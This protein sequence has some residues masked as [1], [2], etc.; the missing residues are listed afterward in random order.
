MM[1]IVWVKLRAGLSQCALHTIAQQ[2]LC[3][4]PAGPAKSPHKKY[5]KD[6]LDYAA[7]LVGDA[8]VFL[9]CEV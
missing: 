6:F 4:A 9:W 3:A 2:F 7:R 5:R 1:V 8:K